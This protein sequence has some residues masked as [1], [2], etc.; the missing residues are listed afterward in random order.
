MRFEYLLYKVSS[1]FLIFRAKMNDSQLKQ[2]QP[3]SSF[4]DQ[5]IKNE[6]NIFNVEPDFGSTMKKTLEENNRERDIL[7]ENSKKKDLNSKFSSAQKS[8]LKTDSQKSILS[9]SLKL[10]AYRASEIKKRNIELIES[11]GRKKHYN[12]REER[13]FIKNLHNAAL[14]I[15]N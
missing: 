1:K 8:E 15:Q 11:F 13:N 14:T 6:M 2:S 12:H 5:T 4:F 3:Q 9:Q 10:V 7:K